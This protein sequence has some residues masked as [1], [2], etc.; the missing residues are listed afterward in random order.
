[1]TELVLAVFRA[2]GAF[3]A[4]GDALVADLGLT[5]ARWQVLGAVSLA[6]RPLTVAQAARRMG[7][8]RQAVQRVANDL[9]AIGL[10]AYEDNPDHK[11]A[12]LIRLTDRGEAVYAEADR[13]QIAWARGLAEGLSD[14]EVERAL[15]L[16][17]RLEGRAEPEAGDDP[18]T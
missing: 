9:A 11:R 5:S 7:L 17:R 15:A 14:A 4:A 13:R 1:M 8:T 16:V 10:V 18:E 6:G 12:K 2:N 3:L